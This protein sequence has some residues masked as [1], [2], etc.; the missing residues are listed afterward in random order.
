M[1]FIQKDIKEFKKRYTHYK[2][3]YNKCN[4]HG[5]SITDY[6]YRIAANFEPGH[7]LLYKTYC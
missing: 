7:G 3:K 5:Y 6:L 1:I 2:Y 4:I